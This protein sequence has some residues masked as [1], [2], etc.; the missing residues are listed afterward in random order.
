MTGALTAP[1]T[2]ASG[3]PARL[4]IDL[5]IILAAA[6]VVAA[7]FRRARLQTITGFVVAGALVGP[8]ALGFVREPE[9][10]EQISSLATVLLMFGIGLHLDMS[11]IRRGLVSIVAIG[12]FS[13]IAVILVL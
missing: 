6:A 4:I 12:A 2:L 1:L 7:A 9:S 13:T 3:E 5:L 10:I 8:H 11:V